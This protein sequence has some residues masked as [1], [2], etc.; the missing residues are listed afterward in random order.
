MILHWEKG[1][2]GYQICKKWLKDR[3][4]RKLDD[5]E[6]WHYQQIV[7]VLAETSRLMNEID[8]AVSSNG[9]N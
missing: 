3:K 1:I 7:A 6:L 8:I 9:S 4:G 5:D 2:G